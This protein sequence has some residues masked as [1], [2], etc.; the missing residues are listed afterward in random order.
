MPFMKEVSHSSQGHALKFSL[1]PSNSL[2]FHEWNDFVV[3]KGGAD[4]DLMDW[5]SNHPEY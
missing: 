1:S 3:S 4:L 5:F 2:C